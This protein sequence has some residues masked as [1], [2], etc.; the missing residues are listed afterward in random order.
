M[1]E[2][3][4]VDF[5]CKALMFSVIWLIT[6][7]LVTEKGAQSVFKKPFLSCMFF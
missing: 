4:W 1:K 2:I 7:K 6:V 3:E 5:N